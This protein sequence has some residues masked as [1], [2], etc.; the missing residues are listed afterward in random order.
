MVRSRACQC[1]RAVAV[2]DVQSGS[3]GQGF[4]YFEEET[5]DEERF[6]ILSRII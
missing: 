2:F 5:A 4:L 1:A 6:K 3:I